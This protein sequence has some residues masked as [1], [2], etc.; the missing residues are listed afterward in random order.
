MHILW[1][2]LKKVDTSEAMTHYESTPFNAKPMEFKEE[3]D[4]LVFPNVFASL[5]TV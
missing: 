3:P 2:H 5:N 4:N 1:T